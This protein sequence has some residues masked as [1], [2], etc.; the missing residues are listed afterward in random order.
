MKTKN[1]KIGKRLNFSK[2]RPATEKTTPETYGDVTR[3]DSQRRF[4]GEHS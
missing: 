3:D 4:S 1:V 2:S